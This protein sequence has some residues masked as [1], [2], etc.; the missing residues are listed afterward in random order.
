MKKPS[1]RVSKITAAAATPVAVVVA[2]G[3]VWQASY[4]AFTGQTRN[5]GNDWSTGEV[6]LTDDDQ[7]A[8]RFQVTNLTPG[9]TQTRCITVTANA[10]VP[11]VVKG[12]AVN[13]VFPS[14]DL[15]QRIKISIREGSG[16]SFASC[17][18]FVAAGT[19]VTGSP[20][21]TLAQANTYDSALGG[22][23]VAAGTQTRTY[24]ITWS[25]DITGMTQA[26]IDEL[27]GDRAGIDIQWELRTS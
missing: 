20:L 21:T 13:P 16:G 4:A 25:F 18:G 22:W 15:A 24:E 19:V 14:P 6:A 1:T 8:A 10:T 23:N 11:G 17:T 27:Q 26:E 12:Y 7:G 2:G 9:D 5:S 3:L